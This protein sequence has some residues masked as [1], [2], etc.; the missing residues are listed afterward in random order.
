MPLLFPLV[1]AAL[2]FAI[3]V[4]AVLV[5]RNAVLVLLGVELMLNAVNLNLVAFD[6]WHRDA[7]HGGQVLTLFAITIAAAE[8]GLGL[9]IVLLVFRTRQQVDVDAVRDLADRDRADEQVAETELRERAE[10]REL[11][12]LAE[13]RRAAATAHDTNGSEAVGSTD[14]ESTDDDPPTG[15]PR[16]ATAEAGR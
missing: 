1:V 10:L 13:R 7:L 11:R 8:I 14:G 12:E 4:Y 5:R 3:G 15:E 6:A 9:A 16:T 2:L